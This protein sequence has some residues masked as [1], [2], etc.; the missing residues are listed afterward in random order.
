MAITDDRYRWD[1]LKSEKKI[2]LEDFSFFAVV[3]FLNI[4]DLMP[5]REPA[6]IIIFTFFIFLLFFIFD[7]A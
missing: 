2:R 5:E 4:F 6:I 1:R 7:L 3:V